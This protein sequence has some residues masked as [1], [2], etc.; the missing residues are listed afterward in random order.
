MGFIIRVGLGLGW[1]L[2]LRLGLGFKSVGLGFKFDKFIFAKR[3]GIKFI[4][5]DLNLSTLI[6]TLI[7]NPNLNLT[8][9]L[10]LNPDE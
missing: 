5:F 8:L 10:I 3:R 9:T 6:L 1:F 7:L 2:V 4:T